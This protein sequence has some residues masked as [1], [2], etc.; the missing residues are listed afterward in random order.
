LSE[1]FLDKIYHAATVT[2]RKLLTIFAYGTNLIDYKDNLLII[3]CN[4][5]ANF[6]EFWGENEN[7]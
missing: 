1:N 7:D 3:N 2:R 6:S 4:L 5:D